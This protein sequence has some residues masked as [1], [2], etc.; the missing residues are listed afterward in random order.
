[1][2]ITPPEELK[3]T[4]D[5]RRPVPSIIWLRVAAA[6]LD[7]LV[8][9]VVW[10]VLDNGLWFL[11]SVSRLLDVVAVWAYHAIMESSSWQATLG[12]RIVGIE[13]SGNDQQA[14]T[15]RQAGI[16]SAARIVSSIMLGGGF[17]LAAFTERNRA[18]HDV[19]ASSLV[20]ERPAGTPWPSLT[21]RIK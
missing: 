1:M 12:K 5:T 13:V 4:I 11:G 20:T 3:I 9:G 2:N 19:I 17:V 14:L 18:L 7:G 21:I 16:R 15:F 6:L 10:S 8:I